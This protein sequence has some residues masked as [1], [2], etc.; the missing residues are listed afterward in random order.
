MSDLKYIDLFC[1]IG[2][3]HAA[4]NALGMQCVLASD[5][6]ASCRAVYERN[7]NLLPVGDIRE[8][9]S[10]D[11]P[12]FDVLFGGFPCQPFSIMGDR[13]GF[14]DDRGT[15]FFEISRILRDRKPSFFILEN[16]KQLTSHD[17]G[18]TLKHILG[19]LRNI[20]YV[21]DYRILNA[22]DFGLPQKR[23]RVL[24]VGWKESRASFAWPNKKIP[25]TPLCDILE[26]VVAEKHFASP[27]IIQKR[28]AAHTPKV[29]PSVWHENKARNISSHPY[30]CALRAQA[31]YNYL[32]V[33]G[34]RRFT[35]R[36]LLR[37]Q[38]FPESFV[39]STKD[40]ENRKQVGN[41]VPVPMIQA[42][43]EAML[44]CQR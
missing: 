42:V 16:V 43:L 14:V 11:I 39:P 30:S 36:E 21:V 32:L 18:K 34:K 33:N 35:P 37:L 17:G 19:T 9:R 38:G 28:K 2:G 20:G 25:M 24:I 26:S 5:I 10:E 1:G 41:S 27:A 8:V 29:T 3:F 22:L 44:Q 6:D 12:D 40:G 15:L 4:A 7:Y 13:E 31:S 23:E